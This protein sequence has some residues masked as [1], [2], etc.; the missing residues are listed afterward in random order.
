MITVPKEPVV[1]SATKVFQAFPKG[2][3]LAVTV[4]DGVVPIPAITVPAAGISQLIN[5]EAPSILSAKGVRNRA[6]H[7]RL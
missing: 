1:C 6:L 4:M 3:P 2:I 5:P 7:F